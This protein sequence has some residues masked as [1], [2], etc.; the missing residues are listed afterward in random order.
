M[1]FSSTF[2]YI[3]IHRDQDTSLEGIPLFIRVKYQTRKRQKERKEIFC[4]NIL[5]D[6]SRLRPLSPLVCVAGWLSVTVVS[7]PWLADS[8]PDSYLCALIG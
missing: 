6:S 1:K 4:G 7:V 2:L 3:F 8:Q 5:N